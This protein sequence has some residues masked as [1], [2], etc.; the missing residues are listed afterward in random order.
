MF[1]RTRKVP[2][3]E[4]HGVN[5]WNA[6]PKPTD[7]LHCRYCDAAITNYEEYVRMAAQQEA[8]R[9]LAEFVETDVS[10]DLAHLK[11][12]LASPGQRISA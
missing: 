4:C 12:I 2:C 9:L 7:V 3:N 8:E 5:Y 10:R 11:S 1:K 6:N